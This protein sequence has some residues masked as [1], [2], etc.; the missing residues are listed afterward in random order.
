MSSIPLS[1]LLT[2][3]SFARANLEREQSFL[4]FENAEKQVLLEVRDAVREI[5]TNTKRVEAY[6]LAGELAEK[7]WK[8]K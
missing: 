6:R 1:N 7:G 2:K 3:A 8:P 4:E 5:E